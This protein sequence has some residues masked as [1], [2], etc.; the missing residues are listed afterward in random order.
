LR[1]ILFV[2]EEQ[3]VLAAH[4]DRM[5]KYASQVDT[6]FSLGGSA[7]LEAV[8]KAAIDAV[9]CDMRTQGPDGA[10]LLG[11][12]KEDHPDIVRITLCSPSELDSIFAALPLSHQIL[13]RPLDPDA[14][15]NV[16]ERTFRLHAL[17]TD[18][19]RKLIG[20]V[21]QLPSVPAVYRELMNAM[22]NPDVSAQ[23]V[24]RIIE[25]DAAMAAKTLQLVNSACF[26]L[27]RTVTGVDQ[28]VAQLGM[29]L[30]KDLSLTVHV[31]AALER[32]ALRLGFSFDA[33]QE[34]SVVTARVAKRLVSN[35]RQAQDAFTAA[36]LHDIGNLVL[37]V[38]I[39]EKFKKAFLACQTSGRPSHE[40]EAELLGVTHAEV[41][42]Y[43]LGL[44][45]LPYPIVEAVA[46][47]HNPAAALERSFDLPTAVSVANALVEEARG[48]LP[49]AFTEHLESLKVLHKLPRWREIA[50][51]ELQ[52]QSPQFA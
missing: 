49:I 24:A 25:K 34:H 32:S 15:C 28:A 13:A 10:L 5:Q 16:I 8:Q 35:K 41:G 17:L 44:W 18:S 33:E 30:I 4:R 23:K 37:A 40:V 47:H 27:K 11:T 48:G 52:Q 36:L 2:A 3:R 14:L 42:A 38:C 51:E 6:M 1:R 22:S 45:G 31:F 12:L 50:M 26:G 19:L 39:P 9:V 43:L 7:A 20:S 21:E 46:Y 29:D